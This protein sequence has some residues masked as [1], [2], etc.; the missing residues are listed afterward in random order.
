MFVLVRDVCTCLVDRPSAAHRR[1]PR[2][3]SPNNVAAKPRWW[4][5]NLNKA[6]N[7]NLAPATNMSDSGHWRRSLSACPVRFPRSVSAHHK[8]PAFDGRPIPTLPL[9][10]HPASSFRVGWPRGPVSARTT[11]VRKPPTE[12]PPKTPNG[13]SGC[14]PVSLRR[15]RGISYARFPG[16]L[17]TES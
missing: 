13:P 17:Q 12:E 7:L 15:D 10:A 2:Q 4:Q 8:P 3:V 14:L 5:A 11:V 6:K 1:Q 9:P 16:A